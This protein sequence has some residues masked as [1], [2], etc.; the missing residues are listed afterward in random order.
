MSSFHSEESKKIGNL[1]IN[2]LY[3]IANIYKCSMYTFD[4]LFFITLRVF[5]SQTL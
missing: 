3:F 5:L 1:M 2:Y 4:T